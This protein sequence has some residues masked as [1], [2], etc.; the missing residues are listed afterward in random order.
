MVTRDTPWD[1]GTP[2]WVDL[3][4]P[5]LDGSRAFYGALFGW[6][7]D[8]GS[9]E[10]GGYTMCRVGDRFV[11]GLGPIM[12]AGHPTVWTTYLA[13]ADINATADKI[14]S[15]GGT[16]VSGPMDVAAVGKM[17]V[18]R[19]STG[20]TF[21]AWQ[22]GEHFGFGLANEPGAVVW[23]E[24]LTRD[25]AGAQKFYAEVE[26]YSYEDMS[27]DE[28]HYATFTPAGSDRPAGGMGDMPP[29]VPDQVPPFWNVYFAVADADA[30]VAKAVDLGGT[31]TFPATDM[32]YG[33]F[34]NLVDPQ[35]G[36][37]SI[38]SQPDQS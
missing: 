5:D 33:R 2:C 3:M 19:D 17:L 25:F 34:A 37:F 32:P 27:N 38:L 9:P 4:S 16:V 29:G 18:A 7:F 13:T 31:V 20:G 15:A 30:T 11:A 8:V 6:E 14:G 35:G 12:Q 1:P 10:F 24:F 26:G 21:A 28:G 36:A 22:P 23:N